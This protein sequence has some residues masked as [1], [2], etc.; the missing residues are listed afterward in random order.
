[1]T[2]RDRTCYSSTTARRTP[3]R[4]SQQDSVSNSVPDRIGLVQPWARLTRVFL[5]FPRA[6][7]SLGAL[8]KCGGQRGWQGIAGPRVAPVQQHHHY[9]QKGRRMTATMTIDNP[10]L[11][12]THRCERCGAAAMVRVTTETLGIWL[13][14]GHCASQ[15][16]DAIP[17]V[18]HVHDERNPV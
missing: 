8:P 13:F 4:I 2:V 9:H 17:G 1:L 3:R 7:A 6:N 11:N 18:R 15:H 16:L 5:P 10:I 12:R 14:C